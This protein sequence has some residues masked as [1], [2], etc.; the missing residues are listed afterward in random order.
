MKQNK[1]Y[2]Y[3]KENAP[4]EVLD[5]I[6]KY[7]DEQKAMFFS[8]QLQFG[9]AGLRGVIGYGSNL[10]NEYNIA[11][12]SL[13]LGQM[14]LQKY[15]E[16]AKQ[17]GIVIAHDNRRNN[18]LYSM[19]AAR[20]LSALGI[21]SSLFHD[22]K[23]QPTPLL[24]FT[25]AKGHF[26]GGINIT[27]SHN[28]PEY[29]GYKVYN[30]IGIQ[31]LPDE[32]DMIIK[33]SLDIK[34]IFNIKQDEK[35]IKYLSESIESQYLQTILKL[36]PFYNID[37][38]KDIKVIFTAQ[39][40][41]AGILASRLMDRMNIDFKMVIE[42]LYPDENFSNTESPNPQNPDSFKLARKY[43]NKENADVLFCTDPDADRFGIEVKHRGEWVHING[44]ELPLIQLKYKLDELKKLDYINKGDFV[45][46]SVVT[47]NAGDYI[48]KKYGIK[49]YE[50]LTGFKWLISES[51]KH[52]MQ[53]NECLFTWEESYG[54]TIRSF[55]RDKDS[56]QALLQVIEIVDLYKRQ[57]KT[58][59]DALED[60]YQEI[61]YF[62]SDQVQIKLTGKDPMT[63]ISEILDNKIRTLNI[64]DSLQSFKITEIKDFSKGYNDLP[65]DNFV[66][67]ILDDN[68]RITFRPSG[69]EPILRVY[70]DAYGKDQSALDKSFKKLQD[71]THYFTN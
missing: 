32:T 5:I 22:N 34:D 18:I 40:G 43:G 53:G 42:Q 66:M 71:L 57:G 2:N 47:S 64:G 11:K 25:I 12:Y 60:I 61:G 7:S 31:M 21:P 67:L 62:K 49:V 38:R 17:Y 51:F 1:E 35:N 33:K 3:W 16:S 55:T 70:I 46:R 48:A 41:T 58:L 52:E 20:V 28:P 45:V 26:V 10:I 36:I 14:L 65:K 37:E 44:N 27:A 19:T 6:E 24:S 50:S 23:L 13:A 4:K 8:S 54:S 56:F 59:V 15:G 68:Q 69:T 9:T 39:H 63:K 30:H 29:S